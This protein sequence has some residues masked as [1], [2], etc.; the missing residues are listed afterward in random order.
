LEPRLRGRKL[1]NASDRF[2]FVELEKARLDREI[3]DSGGTSDADGDRRKCS[4][5]SYH[6]PVAGG[7]L[8][9][10]GRIAAAFFD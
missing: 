9:S 8:P 1:A 4:Q 3:L 6:H 5:S 10:S 7:F 2:P